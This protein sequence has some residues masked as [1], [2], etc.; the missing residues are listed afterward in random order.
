[1]SANKTLRPERGPR[2]NWKFCIY[3]IIRPYYVKVY[4]R[5]Y[6]G[7]GLR[8]GECI[9]QYCT[10]KY[11]L[12][13]VGGDSTW[14]PARRKE[15]EG[16]QVRGRCVPPTAGIDIHDSTTFIFS[17][18]YDGYPILL[19][20]YKI[21]KISLRIVWHIAC[22]RVRLQRLYS[23]LLLVHNYFIPL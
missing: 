1:M 9:I 21:I 22:I 5:D 10:L 2:L 12:N 11:L 6:D 7:R 16:V 23:L 15:A 18:G 4:G 3:C 20:Q 19:L 8:G 17:A 14:H 13:G